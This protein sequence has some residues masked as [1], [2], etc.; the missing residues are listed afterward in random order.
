MSAQWKRQSEN[1]NY[2]QESLVHPS[3]RL[4]LEKE[5][6]ERL[7]HDLTRYMS[8]KITVAQR[9]C[10]AMTDLLTE[11]SPQAIMKKG[12]SFITAKDG[13]YIK[14]A[15][16]LEQEKELTIHWHDGQAD[17]RVVD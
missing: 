3:H 15:A 11:T 17:V 12:Y 6:H 8:E 4:A 2:L 7:S 13:R 10:I 9:Q 1:L 5:R 14:S 16:T